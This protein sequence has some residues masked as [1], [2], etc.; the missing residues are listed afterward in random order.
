MSEFRVTPQGSE[1]VSDDEWLLRRV[2]EVWGPSPSTPFPSLDAFK[3]HRDRDTTGLSLYREKYIPVREL[4]LRGGGKRAYWVARV[5][6]HEVRQTGLSIQP[7]PNDVDGPGHVEIPEMRSDN[8]DTNKVLE[9]AHEL[10]RCCA[11][12]G[13]YR[14]HLDRIQ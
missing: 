2:P 9:W 8:R 4:V 7:R 1:A 10:S 11:V 13:P 12:E 5:R 14:D 6:A 3:P